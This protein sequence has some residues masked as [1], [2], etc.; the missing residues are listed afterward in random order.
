MTAGAVIS[1]IDVFILKLPLSFKRSFS[2]GQ[3]P[4]GGD[5]PWRGSPVMV[6][7]EDREGR[8]GYG[9]MRPVNP[10]L[11]ETTESMASAI[12]RYYAPGLIGANALS[13]GTHAKRLEDLLPDNPG[14]LAI[15]DMAL[16]DLAGHVLGVPAFMLMG[17]Q[18]TRVPLKWTVSTGPIDAM[19]TEARRAVSEYG[20]QILSVK[21]GPAAHWRE[22]A[23]AFRAIRAA[24]GDQIEVGIDGNGSFDPASA[25]RLA[26][27]LE[28]DGL[29]YFEQ[30]LGRDELPELAGL[31]GRV[32]VP[33]LVDESIYTLKDAYRVA[34]ARAGDCMVIK[35]M[36]SGGISRCCDIA[37][38][39]RA[40]GMGYT[41]GGAALR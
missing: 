18:A 32:G 9:R 17:G 28:G 12:R 16:Y 38:I 33:I 8:T 37:A 3:V 4:H 10:F 26:R 11:G 15:L 34:Q 23:E 21:V 6:R 1:R 29:S 40:S 13:V 31:R 25:T 2:K 41:V 36:K 14:A 5:D 30:P 24:V 7:I 39:A 35:L 22:D 20:L 27:A 19:V